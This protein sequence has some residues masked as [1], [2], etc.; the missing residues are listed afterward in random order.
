MKDNPNDDPHRIPGVSSDCFVLEAS[1]LL[2]VLR[3]SIFAACGNAASNQLLASRR[4]RILC[5]QTVEFWLR[6]LYLGVLDSLLED[7]LGRWRNYQQGS[8]DLG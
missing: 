6:Q 4:Y 3:V 1:A 7:N 5:W 2:F 8:R